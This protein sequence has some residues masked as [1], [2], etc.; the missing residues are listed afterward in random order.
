[1]AARTVTA[2]AMT[3]AAT[4]AAMALA[5]AFAAGC[6]RASRETLVSYRSTAFGFTITRPSAWRVVEREDGG[7]VWF[8]PAA[9]QEEDA[10]EARATEFIVVM[11]R[12]APGPLAEAEVRRLAMSLL[13]MHGVSAFQRTAASTEAVAWY[14]FELTGSTGG[15]EWA[16]LGVLVTG[17][18]RLHYAVC[19][20]PLPTWRDR[21]KRCEEVIRSFAPGDLGS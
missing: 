12:A 10:P 11:T 1:M 17:R 18:Q 16:S 14:R 7:R 19:A 3:R 9:L 21:Q 8:L 2:A 4:A 20:G 5:L 6:G 13:P 15:V